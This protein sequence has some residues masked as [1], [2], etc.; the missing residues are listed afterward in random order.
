MREKERFKKGIER[1]WKPGRGERTNERTKRNEGENKVANA[2]GERTEERKRGAK[3]SKGLTRAVAYVSTYADKNVLIWRTLACEGYLDNRKVCALNR[4]GTPRR[5]F[6]EQPFRIFS[7]R[8]KVTFTRVTLSSGSRPTM[9]DS[10]RK[11]DLQVSSKIDKLFSIVAEII[12]LI[13]RDFQ[14]T[15]LYFKIYTRDKDLSVTNS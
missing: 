10:R 1:R 9:R 15:R 11:V 12:E 6:I 2:S 7:T 8:S 5:D 13:Q 3:P 14:N 4:N